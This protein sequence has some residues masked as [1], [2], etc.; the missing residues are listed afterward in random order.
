MAN[1]GGGESEIPIGLNAMCQRACWIILGSITLSWMSKMKS[2]I[3]ANESLTTEFDYINE[4]ADAEATV[5]VEAF[6][7]LQDEAKGKVMPIF[8]L[9]WIIFGFLFAEITIF[10]C[11]FCYAKVGERSSDCD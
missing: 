11:A 10:A 1:S 2:A 9:C 8:V 6:A 7:N 5:D 4:C 3:E